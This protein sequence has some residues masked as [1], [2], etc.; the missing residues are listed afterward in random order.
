M[1]ETPELCQSQLFLSSGQ[2][3]RLRRLTKE[4]DHKAVVVAVDVGGRIRLELD[5][6]VC[7]GRVELEV[8]LLATVLTQD[9]G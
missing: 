1:A 3:H 8:R 7:H 2:R 4:M 5:G 6:D 9:V